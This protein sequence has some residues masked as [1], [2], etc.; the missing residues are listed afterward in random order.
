MMTFKKVVSRK[1]LIRSV[2]VASALTL[3]AGGGVLFTALL[4]GPAASG[5]A[6]SDAPNFPTNAKGETYGSSANVSLANEPDLIFAD[7]TNGAKGYIE[8]RQLWADD[9]TDVTSRTAAAAYMASA[10]APRFIPV[11][12]QDGT[13]VI[14]E[15]EIP[16]VSPTLASGQVAPKASS[17][18]P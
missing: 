1:S 13:T 3:G 8:R 4:S 5:A 7:A 15:F 18:T 2:V 17:S 14:G 11:Y 10:T 6:T 16:G 12:A 9:G